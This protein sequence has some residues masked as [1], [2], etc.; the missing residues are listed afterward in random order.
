[1]KGVTT[2]YLSVVLAFLTGCSTMKKLSS[3]TTVYHYANG[4]V[5]DSDNKIVAHYANGFVTKYS[6][7]ATPKHIKINS[8]L[9]LFK[10][11]P[12]C[13]LYTAWADMGHWG[14]VG[15]NGLVVISKA[16]ALLIDSP[17][18]ASQT[19]ELAWWFDNNLTVTFESF[20]PG[21]WHDDCVGG[22]AWLNR[23]GAKTYA[24]RLTNEILASKGL[25]QSNVSFSDSLSIKVG[26][27]KVE[28][29]Y[30][31]GGHSTDNIV[32]WI[33][34][35]KILFGG[36]MLKDMTAQNIGNTS[37][38]VPLEEWL[39]TIKQV[40]QQF[41]DVKYVVPGHGKYGGKELFK[42]SK[43]II[44]NEQQSKMRK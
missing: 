3:G 13:Y 29:Y 24:N 31:G 16:K 43:T 34:S 7:I 41:P 21:H 9:E 1:M 37:D 40:E 28:A 23:N 10:L 32:V 19:V 39:Q 14:R 36:C 38:A 33:P 27:I 11:T 6:D 30:L 44:E 12:D 18:L 4:F 5:T 35:E 20:I 25:E 22:L 8:D 26:N 42:H 17:T 2:V 15:S